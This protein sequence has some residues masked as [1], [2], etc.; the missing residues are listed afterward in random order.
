MKLCLSVAL[1]TLGPFIEACLLS[2]CVF[3]QIVIECLNLDSDWIPQAVPY[4][5]SVI[6][7][8]VIHCLQSI[9]TKRPMSLRSGNIIVQS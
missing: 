3:Y 8:N 1:G 5:H 7:G 2:N 9:D 4:L 6:C